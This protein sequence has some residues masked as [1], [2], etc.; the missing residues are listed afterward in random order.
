MSSRR[1]SAGVLHAGKGP[2][3]DFGGELLGGLEVFEDL[4]D[5]FTGLF[6]REDANGSGVFEDVVGEGVKRS[7]QDLGGGFLPHEGEEALAHFPGGLFGEGDGGDGLRVHALADE[8]GDAVDHGAGLAAT[9]SGDDE[10][11]SG[12]V[13]GYRFLFRVEHGEPSW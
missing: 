10:G 4:P 5:E 8:A 6:R 13:V 12:E 3:G 2:L 11:G 7:G 1:P 9:G